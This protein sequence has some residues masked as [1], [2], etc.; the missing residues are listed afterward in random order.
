M[1]LMHKMYATWLQTKW[2]TKIDTQLAQVVHINYILININIDLQTSL[3][4]FL[5]L[6]G[7]SYFN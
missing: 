4:H 1:D 3:I 5:V 2:Q 6:T 7:A